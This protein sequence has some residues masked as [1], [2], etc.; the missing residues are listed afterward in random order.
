MKRESLRYLQNAKNILKNIPVEDNFYTDVKPVR[1][2]FAT[3][4]L[5]LLEAINEVLIKRG[6][7]KKELPKSVD[8]YRKA[9]KKYL[10]VHN[11]KLLRDFEGLY[12]TLHI[13]SYY[14]GLIY[15]A[16]MVKEALKSTKAFMGKI[17]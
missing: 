8:S 13:A 11:G 17:R 2:A 15:N 10:A 6:F 12:D 16:N 4:Y 1:E 9:L 14:R 7:T 3:A 5:A